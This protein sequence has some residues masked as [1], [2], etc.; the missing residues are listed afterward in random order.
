MKKKRSKILVPMVLATLMA[1]MCAFSW[2]LIYMNSHYERVYG[3]TVDSAGTWHPYAGDYY[4]VYDRS[5]DLNAFIIVFVLSF[6]FF[7]WFLI[8]VEEEVKQQK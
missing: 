4:T 1:L 6:V 5:F 2:E 7:S 8:G 3:Y